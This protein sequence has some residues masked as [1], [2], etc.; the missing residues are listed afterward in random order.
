MKKYQTLVLLLLICGALRALMEF[1]PPMV[2]AY[3]AKNKIITQPL[4]YLTIGTIG[5]ILGL[6]IWAPVA[7][8]VHKDAKENLFASWLW[9]LFILFFGFQGVIFYVLLRILVGKEKQQA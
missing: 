8:W 3:L 6:I 1:I 9:L 5:I 2:V 7:I 4:N